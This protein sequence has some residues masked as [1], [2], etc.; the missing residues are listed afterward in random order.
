MMLGLVMA[1]TIEDEGWALKVAHII[2]GKLL[3]YVLHPVWV[4][5]IRWQVVQVTH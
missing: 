4:G 5:H 2:P 1:V 3:G